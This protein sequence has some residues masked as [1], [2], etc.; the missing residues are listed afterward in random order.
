MNCSD[1]EP[2]DIDLLDIPQEISEDKIRS[3]IKEILEMCGRPNAAVCVAFMD[4]PSIRRLNKEFRKIDAPTDVLA[5]PA[6]DSPETNYLGDI[7]ISVPAARRQATELGHTFE[8]ELLILTCHG[9]LHLCGY[10]HETDEGEMDELEARV[11]LD[12][13]SKYC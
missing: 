12:V 8:K 5:F 7:A 4:D 1:N 9:I 11:E 2:P 13:I 6:G 10:D 3:L